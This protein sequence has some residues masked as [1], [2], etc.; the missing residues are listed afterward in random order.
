MYFCVAQIENAMEGM[1]TRMVDKVNTQ[2][3]VLGDQLSG[4]I[5][6]SV[7]DEAEIARRQ[8]M[9]SDVAQIKYDLE[10]IKARL[11]ISTNAPAPRP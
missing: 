4:Q 9:E 3:R 6:L 7:P 5:K 11:G 1:E 8:E 2:S 10:Q